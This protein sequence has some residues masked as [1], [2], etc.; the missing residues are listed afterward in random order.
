MLDT[1]RAS[2]LNTFDPALSIQHKFDGKLRR[3]KKHT[4][5]FTSLSLFRDEVEC[6]LRD[7]YGDVESEALDSIVWAVFR[8]VEA[9]TQYV[10]PDLWKEHQDAEDLDYMLG[11]GVPEGYGISGG[12]WRRGMVAKHDLMLRVCEVRENPSAFSAYTGEFAARFGEMW[13]CSV[14][15]AAKTIAAAMD[16]RLRIL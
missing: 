12:E 7:L 10:R 14:E 6:L 5:D 1:I 3:Q 15:A 8:I 9:F 13:D 11:I 16:P 4:Q 2:H